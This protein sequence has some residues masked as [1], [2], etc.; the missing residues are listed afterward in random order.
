MQQQIPG[1]SKC[2]PAPCN[3]YSISVT[4]LN[5]VFSFF[6]SYRHPPPPQI[7]LFLFGFRQIPKR[8]RKNSCEGLF[9]LRKRE[10]E[11]KKMI[12][13]KE[14]WGERERERQEYRGKEGPTPTVPSCQSPTR[15][16][17]TNDSKK[18][19][20]PRSPNGTRAA[21]RPLQ[22]SCPR[23]QSGVNNRRLYLTMQSP[24]YFG[25]TSVSY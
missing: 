18:H 2:P 10:K 17:N 21:L 24:D 1:K 5:T 9:K 20:R 3:L 14:G 4:A 13:E 19:Q 16:T 23:F 7:F 15:R 25:P 6:V 22:I 11:R 12:A 8:A